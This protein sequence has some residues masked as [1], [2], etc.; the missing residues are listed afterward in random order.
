M[1]K[2]NQNFKISPKIKKQEGLGLGLPQMQGIKVI[3]L[4]NSKINCQNKLS[5][6]SGEFGLMHERNIEDD[7]TTLKHSTQIASFSI[8]DD[9][10]LPIRNSCIAVDHIVEEESHTLEGTGKKTV[11]IKSRKN[12]ETDNSFTKLKKLHNKPGYRTNR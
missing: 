1:R 12:L 10:P 8:N 2:T 5:T 3:E 11:L 7:V 6:S 9:E 4:E